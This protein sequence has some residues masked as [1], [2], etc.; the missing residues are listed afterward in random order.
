VGTVLSV[1]VGRPRTVEHN[2]RPVTTAIYKQPVA[3]RVALRGVNLDGDGQA[4]RTVHGGVDKAVYAYAREDT[5]VLK[6]GTGEDASS[7]SPSYQPERDD[8]SG[9][10]VSAPEPSPPR[11][12]LGSMR[13][14][15]SKLSGEEHS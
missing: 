11:R 6:S 1:N 2:G 12:A 8:L 5:R 3:G 10:A 14:S 7:G 4:D 13:S 15:D 9:L